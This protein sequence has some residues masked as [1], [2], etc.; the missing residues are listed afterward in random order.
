MGV[1]YKLK[2][3]VVSYILDQKRHHPALSC[4]GMVGQVRQV[5][6]VDVSKSSINAVI[7]AAQL[8]SPVGRHSLSGKSMQK[9]AIPDEKKEQFFSETLRAQFS[10]GKKEKQKKAQSAPDLSQDRVKIES[11]TGELLDCMG[12]FFL[13]AAQ[14]LITEESIVGGIL[15]EHV[16]D[17]SRKEIDAIC[18]VLLYSEAFNIQG[19]KEL[20]SYSKKGLWLLNGL[21]KKI[22]YHSVAKVSKK[23]RNIKN[24]DLEMSSRIAPLLGEVSFYS[25][26]V[27]DSTR[28]LLDANLRIICSEHDN[29]INSIAD[30]KA[31]SVMSSQLINNLSPAIISSVPEEGVFSEDFLNFITAFENY[32]GKALTQISLLDCEKNEIAA[33]TTIPKQKRFFITAAWPWQPGF[34][35]IYEECANLPRQLISDKIF[36]RE[37]YYSASGTKFMKKYFNGPNLPI[38]AFLVGEV[39]NKK[40][41]AAL[42][43]NIPEETMPLKDVVLAYLLRWP[44]LSAGQGDFLAKE[45][46]KHIANEREKGMLLESQI[47]AN[48]PEEIAGRQEDS[49]GYL[50]S[51]LNQYCQKHFF[52]SQ[53]HDIDIKSMMS[54][55]YKSKGVIEEGEDYVF[56]R[57]ELPQ[58]SLWCKEDL[59]VAI[60]KLNESDVVDPKG[61]RLF[62]GLRK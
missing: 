12:C 53:Y 25:I 50:L 47:F 42:L 61:R 18:D 26:T 8:S 16:S 19:P 22:N 49:F 27:E 58:E 62:L 36:G 28:I 57:I 14:W 6:D 9:F 23:I 29:V 5:F 20:A 1:I 59:L 48:N 38:R 52:P 10:T 30:Q 7:K 60:K 39:N 33:F 13:K 21:D 3:E 31:I 35:A 4:R 37:V 43:T 24:F 34:T 46:K 40:P 55:L 32:E 2:E 17:F 51:I 56:V 44:D 11:K 45:T 15:S 41:K 54:M